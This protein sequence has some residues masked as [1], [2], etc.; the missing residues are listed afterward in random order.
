LV[1]WQAGEN[2]NDRFFGHDKREIRKR[3][4]PHRWC[5]IFTSKL[6]CSHVLQLTATYK[7]VHTTQLK[8]VDKVTPDA[9]LEKRA[10]R[11]LGAI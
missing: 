1:Y 8:G 7:C 2:S 5:K 4:M 6:C 10:N 11:P 9:I 3:I